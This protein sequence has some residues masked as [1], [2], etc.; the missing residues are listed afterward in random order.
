VNADFGPPLHSF[1]VCGKM[2]ELETDYLKLFQY[3]KQ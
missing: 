3:K 1:V 2:H